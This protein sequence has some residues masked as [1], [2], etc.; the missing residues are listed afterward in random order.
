M[1]KTPDLN[2]RDVMADTTVTIRVRG[3]TTFGWRMKL[4]MFLLNI[5][6][7][8]CPVDTV[9]DAAVHKRTRN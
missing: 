5:A 3:T 8:V 9:I 2:M 7:G 6:S 4:T 1:V